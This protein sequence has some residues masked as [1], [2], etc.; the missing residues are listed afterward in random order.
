[1]WEKTINTR[2]LYGISWQ[3]QLCRQQS[4]STIVKRS[5]ISPH[6]FGARARWPIASCRVQCPNV[7]RDT[8]GNSVVVTWLLKRV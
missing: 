5:V 3:R 6:P 8:A 2:Q 1:M 4:T 7:S